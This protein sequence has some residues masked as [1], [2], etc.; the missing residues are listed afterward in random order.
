[1]KKL[2][3]KIGIGLA[4]VAGALP[5]FSQV[6]DYGYVTKTA[7]GTTAANAVFAAETSST[8]QLLSYTLTTDLPT[9]GGVRFYGGTE[10]YTMI[11]N[12]TANASNFVCAAIANAAAGDV[13]VFQSASTKSNYVGSIIAVGGTTNIMM[14]GN[15]SN[16]VA[17]VIGDSI[18]RMALITTN[19]FKPG[20]NSV[21]RD[22][23]AIFSSRLRTPLLVRGIGTSAVTLDSVTV[24][25]NLDE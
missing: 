13:I 16:S 3:L 1:M 8:I 15:V 23:P 17:L 6:I 5:S 12:A 7:A 2:I 10:R 9:T 11:S 19:L 4:A 24:R 25:Y 21:M 20:T 18:Y 22:G 14:A